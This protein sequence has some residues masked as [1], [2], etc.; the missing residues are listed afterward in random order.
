MSLAANPLCYMTR[1]LSFSMQ[2]W[3]IFAKIS[4][5]CLI[6]PTVPVR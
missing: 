4:N 2:L 1:N 6:A 5:F 3:L